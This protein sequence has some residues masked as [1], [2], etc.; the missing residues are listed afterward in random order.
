[1]FSFW[2]T[3]RLCL[4]HH[5]RNRCSNCCRPQLRGVATSSNRSFINKPVL[6][7]QWF[8]IQKRDEK[9][10]K[11]EPTVF[12]NTLVQG[13]NEA[14][15]DLE[16]VA[17]V[18]DSG[19]RLNYSHWQCVYPGQN[20]TEDG[21][22]TRMTNHC[23][24]S[25]NEDHET[26]GNYAQVFN[27]LIRKYKYLE[28]AFEDEMKKLLLLLTAFSETE[29]TKLAML[30]GI[31]LGN[32]AL[33]ATIL[34]SLFMG[35]LVKEVMAEKDANSVTSSLRKVVLDERLLE[36]FAVKRRSVDHFAEY[37]TDTGLKELSG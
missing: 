19:S 25:A 17:K 8:E 2:K 26:I 11:F 4:R 7:G 3:V 14:G 5:P 30:S 23:M 36:L 37:F 35:N 28:K 10:G 32:G 16:T 34:T 20:T 29:Q 27:K 6:P 31:L 1:M 24:F 22:K 12:R 15:D 13:L 18:L 33:P 9:K 21:D